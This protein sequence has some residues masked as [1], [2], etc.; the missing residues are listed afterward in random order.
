MSGLEVKGHGHTWVQVYGGE[1]IH[2]DA[3]ASKSSS[4]NACFDT[5]AKLGDRKTSGRASYTQMFL[6]GW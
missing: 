2:V 3:G 1:V 6:S 5:L 4:Y